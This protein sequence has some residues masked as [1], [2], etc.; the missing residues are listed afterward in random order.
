MVTTIATSPPR[1]RGLSI[2]IPVYNKARLLPR[3]LESIERQNISELEVVAVDN[4]STDDSRK[5]LESWRDRL[6][7]KIHSLPKTISLHDNWLLA[8]SLGTREHLKLQ[9]ADDVIPDG[10]V[11]QLWQHL[12]SHPE[13]GFVLGNTLPIDEQSK[14]ISGGGTRDFW[15][16]VNGI[17]ARMGRARTLKERADCLASMRIGWSLFGDANAAI[18]RAELLP[19][20]RLGVDNS[21]AAFQAWPEYEIILRLFAAANCAHLDLASS[22]FSYD[23]DGHLAR[24]QSLTLRRRIFDMPAASQIFL[25]LLDPDLRPLVRLAGWRYQFKLALWFAAKHTMVHY[26]KR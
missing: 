7:L 2:C 6:N 20:L 19:V 16:E 11:N 24:I 1:A 13:L 23:A 4:G 22:L 21:A 14:I 12:Q 26:G 8:L 25:L 3:T 9:L 10:A 15:N 5:V 18:F 17:R